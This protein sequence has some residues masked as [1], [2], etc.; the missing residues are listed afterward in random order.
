MKIGTRAMHAG[1]RFHP[2]GAHTPP[3]F[4]TGTFIF[5][6][7]KEA[8]KVFKGKKKGF[9]YTRVGWGNPNFLMV[10]EAIASLE[11]AQDA[12][13]FSSGM[14]A[15]NTTIQ[16]IAAGGGHIICGRTLYGGTEALFSKI[17]PQLGLEFSFVDT[18]YPEN[19]KKAIKKNT[20]AVFLEPI[21]NPTLDI[22]DIKAISEIAHQEGILLIADTSLSSPYNLKPLDFGA[23]IVIESTTKYLNGHGDILS[24]S[25]AGTKHFLRE[26]NHS[27][28]EW[29]GT[30]GPIASPFDCW[31][32]LRG[33]LTFGQRMETH[34]NNAL[35]LAQFLEHHPAIKKV[36][37]PGL[38]SHPQHELAKRQ[39]IGGFGG[40]VSFELNGGRKITRKF[41]ETLI[42][43]SFVALAVSLGYTETLIEC[44]ALMTHASIPR[45]ERISKGITDNLIRLSVG[46]EDYEDIEESFKK[47]LKSIRAFAFSSINI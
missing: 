47:A 17:L 1:I 9:A 4:Q 29:R 45:E 16:N 23:D 36:I 28:E 44:P 34:N 8:I 35:R 38:E 24:G 25:V 33:L 7:L 30:Q 32:L 2:E 42:K 31:L 14:A 12:L 40:M 10:E 46:I 11:G 5:E 43:N 26:R 37:Y 18:R 22:S 13:V 39:T 41:L 15:I 6:S 3:I 19:V 20:K 21:A 27:L